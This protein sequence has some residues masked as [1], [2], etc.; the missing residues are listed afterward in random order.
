VRRAGRV[1]AAA[2]AWLLVVAIGC[3]GGTAA[4]DG[5]AGGDAAPGGDAGHDAVVQTDGGGDSGRDGGSAGACAADLAALRALVQ[6]LPSA[7]SDTARD[8]LVAGFFTTVA[9]GECGLPIRAEGKLGVAVRIDGGGSFTLAGDFNGWSASALPMLQP[10]AGFHF[11]YLITPITEPLPR[12]LYKVVRDGSEWMADPMARRYGWDGNGQYSLAEAGTA[13]SHLERWPAFAESVGALEPRDLVVYVPAGD[14]ALARP[15]LYMHDGQNLFDPD[16]MWGGWKVGETADTLIASAQM[17]PLLIVGVYNTVDR[18]DEYTHCPDDI[19]G[20]TIVGGRADEYLDFLVDGVKP[21]VEARYAVTAGKATTG[22]MG[23]SL[24]GLVS[25]YAA[26]KHPGVFGYAGSMSG[27]FFWGEGLGNPTM[28]S[29]VDA[30]PPT[31]VS[32]Y[33]DS[34]GD[35]TCPG[36]GDNYCETVALANVLRGHGWVDGT[37]LFYAWAPDAQHN[38]AA[39]AARLPG[40]LQSWYPGP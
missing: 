25:V 5:P 26:V 23:S 11:Y 40:A 18:M 8:A 35:S 4:T 10:V 7:A 39:W 31:G 2:L 22:V 1:R 30:T 28:A 29:L 38:E 33:L 9:Y 12:T 17:R 36:G 6:A 3:G 37:D 15:V 24:G 14:M 27:S 16:A 32:F 21:F 34:G 20:G 19:G 13:Q